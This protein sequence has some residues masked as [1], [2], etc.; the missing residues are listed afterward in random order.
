MSSMGSR[1]RSWN[2]K[3][4]V[5]ISFRKG[6]GGGGGGGGGVQLLSIKLSLWGG[7]GGGGWFQ[8]ACLPPHLPGSV[9]GIKI[10]LSIKG[11]GEPDSKLS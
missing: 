4:P 11:W 7:G 10:F 6:G 3:G 8:T 2:L 9:P 1:D 5:V